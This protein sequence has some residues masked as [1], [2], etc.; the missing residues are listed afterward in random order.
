MGVKK[1][2]PLPNTWVEYTNTDFERWTIRW[3]GKNK[4]DGGSYKSWVEGQMVQTFIKLKG[5]DFG[6]F[7]NTNASFCYDTKA[8][9]DIIEKVEMQKDMKILEMKSQRKTELLAASN[10]ALFVQYVDKLDKIDFTA[11]SRQNLIDKETIAKCAKLYKKSQ[12]LK[13]QTNEN[14]QNESNASNTNNKP[15]KTKK[16][17]KNKRK[18]N[19]V[20]Q[21]PQAKRAKH[22]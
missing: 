22:K 2:I 21:G 12:G 8:K 11:N 7:D 17:K 18:N 10:N 4:H 19:I 14:T 15:N 6:D 13:K 20:I 9:R 16:K 3:Q 5:I 1:K